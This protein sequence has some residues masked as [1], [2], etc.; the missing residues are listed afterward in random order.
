MQ[1]NSTNQVSDLKHVCFLGIKHSFLEARYKPEQLVINTMFNTL[2]HEEEA[3]IF[4]RDKADKL[5]Q[6]GEFLPKCDLNR[7]LA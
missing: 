4:E 7:F 3:S 1:W 6:Q 2:S 5:T